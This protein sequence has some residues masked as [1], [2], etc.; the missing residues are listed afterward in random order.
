[1]PSGEGLTSAQATLPTRL[2]LVSAGI[3]WV[4]FA[5]PLFRKV[6]EPPRRLESDETPGAGS[7]GAAFTRLGETLRELRSYK[8]AFLMLLAFLIYSDGIGTIIR[9]AGIYGASLGI[10]RGSLIAAILITQFVGVPFALIF[11]GVAGRIGAKKG[12]LIGLVVYM[13]ITVVG[14]FMTNATHFLILAV[15][16]GMVQGGTQALSRSLF[17]RMIPRHKSGEF[18]GLYGVMDR[19]SGSAGTLVMSA[20]AVATGEARFGILAIMVFFIAGALV[21]T[22]VDVSAGEAAARE[23]ERQAGVFIDG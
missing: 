12:I 8:H 4:L 1:L 11:G 10:E 13:A 23:A 17:A 9:M 6:S 16:V 7:L 5:I 18:F 2:A 19:F 3:W 15:L 20:V 22:R 21:L 14:Y